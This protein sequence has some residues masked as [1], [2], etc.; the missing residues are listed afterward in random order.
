MKL[1]IPEVS[2]VLLVGPS[3]SGK[4]TFGRKHFL[5]SEVISS[6]YCRYLISDDENDQAA[7]EHAFEILR[8]IARKRLAAGKLVVVDATNVQ[9]KA[10][11]PLLDL[12]R[13]LG[14]VPVAIVLQLPEGLC[15]ERNRSRPG[16]TVG[17]DIIQYQS[18]ELH[19]SLPGMD[20]EGFRYIY[21][22]DSPEKIDAVSVERLSSA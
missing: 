15:G 1:T 2:L 5:A 14:V 17:G 3:G 4:T 7:T 6:D 12:A 22:L 21:V 19:L 10:R 13:E 9:P 18:R 20:L 11:Q 8:L 16:R